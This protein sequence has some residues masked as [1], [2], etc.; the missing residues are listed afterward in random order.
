MRLVGA[1]SASTLGV[2]TPLSGPLGV[3]LVCSMLLRGDSDVYQRL[4]REI[5]LKA[6]AH[7]RQY[8]VAIC[9]GPGS[10]KSTLAKKLCAAL[11]EHAVELPM[12]GFHFYRHELDAFDDPIAAHDRRGAPF[13][14]N[15]HKFVERLRQVR[16]AEAG[17]WPSFDHARG[18]PVEDDIHLEP[19]HQVVLV[20]G[21]YLLLDE[22]PWRD[23]RELFDERWF[24]SV[25]E[26]LARQRVA[27]RNAAAWG[28]PLEKALARTD[29]NDV[30]NMRLVSATSV[31]ADRIIDGE[32]LERGELVFIAP[33]QLMP[34]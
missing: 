19:H 25:P 21:N 18:D 30:P 20:D 26:A 3:P 11:G 12:D 13:T 17:P 4:G 9:G 34:S 31:H 23:V 6:Q 29:S 24:V 15:A 1:T 33:T 5:E 2:R 27:S 16:S 32:A 14:F 8:F 22:S 10:G 28:W 7:G